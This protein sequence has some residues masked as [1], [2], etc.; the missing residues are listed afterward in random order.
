MGLDCI[1]CVW[2]SAQTLHSALPVQHC[3]TLD[4][5]SSGQLAASQGVNLV[6]MLIGWFHLAHSFS[7]IAHHFP[8]D[9]P[10]AFPTENVST[11]KNET[12]YSVTLLRERISQAVPAYPVSRLHRTDP[13]M[14]ISKTLHLGKTNTTMSPSLDL[15]GQTCVH[16]AQHSWY[17]WPTS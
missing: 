8:E 11:L 1:S 13:D 4:K 2:Q 15:A 5:D 10:S 12:L 9:I 17:T 14:P 16:G 3:E 6:N 7:S